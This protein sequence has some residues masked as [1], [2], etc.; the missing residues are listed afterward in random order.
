MPLIRRGA[1][2]PPGPADAPEEAIH[3]GGGPEPAAAARRQAAR[4]LAQAGDAAG[5]A[6]WLAREADPSVR[7]LLFTGLIGI[8]DPQ[9]LTALLRSEDA[10]LRVGAAG[11]LRILAP[12]ALRLLPDLLADPDPDVR[13]LATDIASGL[14]AAAATSVLIP[15]LRDDPD[16]NV[17]AAA[18][19]VL[20]AIGTADAVPALLALPG[21]FGGSPFLQF[22]CAAAVA[23]LRGAAPA[24]EPGARPA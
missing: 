17:C 1:G 7:E 16:E 11:A 19:E 22:S 4:A 8:G 24:M 12:A 13:V 5:L 20:C 23:A 18:V 15:V 10:A 21:R 14:P 2:G 6:G 3:D 9:P